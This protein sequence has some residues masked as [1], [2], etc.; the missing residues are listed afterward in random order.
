MLTDQSD[1]GIFPV[2]VSSLKDPSLCQV[3]INTSQPNSPTHYLK[4]DEICVHVCIHMCAG[5][6]ACVYMWKAEV[7]IMFLSITLYLFYFL[8]QSFLKPVTH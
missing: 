8:R 4:H 7:S 6:H 5:A 3:D 2:E 1:G